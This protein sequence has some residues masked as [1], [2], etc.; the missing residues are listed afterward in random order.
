MKTVLTAFCITISAAAVACCFG[1]ACLR[2]LCAATGP[3]L[4]LAWLGQGVQEGL[5]G[6]GG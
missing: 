1:Y 2:L 3:V 4:A 5:A 6:A